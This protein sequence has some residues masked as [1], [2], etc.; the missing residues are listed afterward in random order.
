MEK[1][2]YAADGRLLSIDYS[3]PEDRYSDPALALPRAWEPYMR[4]L[5]PVILL[6]IVFE[7]LR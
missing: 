4:W 7:S 6:G 3:N 2:E 1:R 5:L